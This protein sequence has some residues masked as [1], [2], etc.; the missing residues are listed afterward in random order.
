LLQQR[1][2]S[3]ASWRIFTKK[4]QIFKDVACGNSMLIPR[5]LAENCPLPAEKCPASAQPQ[6]MPT[7]NAL[8]GDWG[9]WSLWSA[10]TT[11]CGQTG[12]SIRSRTCSVSNRCEGSPNESQ[13][14]N[15]KEC[16]QGR[17]SE[18]QWSD[19]TPWNTCSG[20]FYVI[21]FSYEKTDQ[22]H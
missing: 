19:W 20:W 3:N 17:S 7:G 5:D 21:T 6:P 15:R 14:C 11:S 2:L 9:Q 1:R 12:V 16:P 10:C 4:L 8:T 13:E 22:L 18:P